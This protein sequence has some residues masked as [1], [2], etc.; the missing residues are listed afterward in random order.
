MRFTSCASCPTIKTMSRRLP[1]ILLR[2]TTKKSLPSLPYLI[3]SPFLLFVLTSRI[4]R[5]ISLPHS[6]RIPHPTRTMARPKSL[7]RRLRLRLVPPH[8]P[9]PPRSLPPLLS[10]HRRPP[11]PLRFQRPRRTHSRNFRPPRQR[12]PRR[13]YFQDRV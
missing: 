11:S 7:P 2:H 13:L 3:P 12:R 10:Q 1:D 8:K 4:I 6:K 9:L 5:S